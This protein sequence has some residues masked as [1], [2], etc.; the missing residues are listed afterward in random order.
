MFE[1]IVSSGCF[2]SNPVDGELAKCDYLE[3][4]E[5]SEKVYEEAVARA[6]EFLQSDDALVFE[7][8]IMDG[9]LFIPI[10]TLVEKGHQLNIVE[11]IAKS[12][13]PSKYDGLV[14][15]RGHHCFSSISSSSSEFNR[16]RSAFLRVH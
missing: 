11:V 3:G 7:A 9:A 1:D 5:V 14:S 16:N 12:L 2:H 15:L 8:G 13:P 10:I 4:I 6:G